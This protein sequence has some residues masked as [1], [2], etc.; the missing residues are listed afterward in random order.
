M[1]SGG[2]AKCQ[3]PGPTLMYFVHGGSY[4]SNIYL[5]VGVFGTVSVIIVK[6]LKIRRKRKK[7]KKKRVFSWPWGL[8]YIVPMW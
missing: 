5:S 1:Q 2:E 7:K 4:F 6:K 8:I 3:T